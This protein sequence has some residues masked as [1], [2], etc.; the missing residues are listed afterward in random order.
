VNVKRITQFLGDLAS[1]DDRLLLRWEHFSRSLRTDPADCPITP[2]ALDHLL[3]GPKIVR[4]GYLTH[5]V[6]RRI[7]P[8]M[9]NRASQALVQRITTLAANFAGLAAATRIECPNFHSLTMPCRHLIILHPIVPETTSLRRRTGRPA[10]QIFQPAY[11]CTPDHWV[12]HRQNLTGFASVS[13]ASG[14]WQN[15]WV[16]LPGVIHQTGKQLSKNALWGR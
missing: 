1:K 13:V 4:A 6:N 7:A 11:N 15:M 12:L 9:R 5:N 3:Y 16:A 10:S 8:E 2:T 14:K